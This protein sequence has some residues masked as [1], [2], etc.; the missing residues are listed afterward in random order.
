MKTNASITFSPQVLY[1]Y[2]VTERASPT[3]FHTIHRGIGVVVLHPATGDVMVTGHYRTREARAVKGLFTL[4]N[5]LQAGRILIL[6]APHHP[7]NLRTC[8]HPNHHYCHFNHNYYIIITIFTVIITVSIAAS[9][10]HSPYK[11][12]WRAQI[13]EED[14]ELLHQ[15]VGG[16]WME[17]VCLGE[18]WAAVGL[19]DGPLWA[20]AA[21]TMGNLTIPMTSSKPLH[22]AVTVPKFPPE[23]RCAWY[24]LP[25]H[26][27]RAKFCETYEGYGD[28]CDCNTTSIISPANAVGICT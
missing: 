14:L 4:L 19:I 28:F 10:P 25:E 11:G 6:A 26:A 15:Y 27:E 12:D 17:N 18:M 7:F 9:L 5:N 1:M 21:T 24:A 20:E 3:S 22:I 13:R 23:Q 16:W 2:N 8:H